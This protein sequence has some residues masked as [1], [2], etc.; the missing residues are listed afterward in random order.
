MT[1]L[2][3]ELLVRCTHLHLEGRA[4]EFP[5]DKDGKPL[6][7]RMSVAMQNNYEMVMASV[8]KD[9]SHPEIVPAK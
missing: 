1:T 2:P 9:F 6:I 5:C 4:F 8:G 3:K 7:T